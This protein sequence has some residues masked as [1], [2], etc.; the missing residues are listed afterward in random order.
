MQWKVHG[1]QILY[2]SEWVTLELANVELPDGRRLDHHVVRMPR[3]SA[4][5]AVVDAGRVLML[6]RHRFIT[7][8][9]GWELPAGWV[10]P[11]EDPAMTA[12]REVEEETGWRPGPLTL[13]TSFASDHGITD[14][15]F[16]VYRADAAA[17]QGGP[18]DS[19]EASRVEW[20]PLD[21][22]RA[23]IRAGEIDEGAS[24]VALSLVL[25]DRS[26]R[27]QGC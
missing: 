5:V 13:L 7:D 21:K 1:H 16:F 9:W 14:S 20:I 23:M 18:E 15:R 8:R 10:D 22:V 24:L 27:P 3:Q 6:W 12:R 26:S 19:N 25:L 2:T 4:V 17:F 11:G